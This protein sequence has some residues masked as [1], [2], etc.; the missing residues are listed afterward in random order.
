MFD[1]VF[2]RVYN[3]SGLQVPWYALLG[4]HDW[5]SLSSP[6]LQINATRRWS[7]RWRMPRSCRRSTRSARCS[8]A[9]Q[10]LPT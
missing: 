2:E 6:A 9:G 5:R 7:P 10:R 8:C 4:N 3:G 1:R